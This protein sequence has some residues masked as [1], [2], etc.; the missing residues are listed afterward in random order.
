MGKVAKP[1]ALEF[2]EQELGGP[3]YEQ[4]S[5]VAYNNSTTTVLVG[6]NGDRVGLLIFNQSAGDITVGL[7]G[8]L[9][10]GNGIILPA[11]GGSLTL[12]VRDDFTLAARQWFVC[13]NTGG[14]V[15]VLEI[16]RYRSSPS[17]DNT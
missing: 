2:T 6:N 13:S 9:T 17:E 11:N 5:Q 10:F 14:L 7:L 4:D 16:I 8:S 12:N 1:A 3:C 15:T